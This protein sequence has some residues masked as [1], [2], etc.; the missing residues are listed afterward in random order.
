MV[1]AFSHFNLM[2]PILAIRL[3]EMNLSTMQIG[4]FFMI[5]PAFYI[6]CGLTIHLISKK[7]EKRVRL[8][9]AI[10]GISV[11]YLFAGPSQLLYFPDSLLLMCIG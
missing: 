11:G 4:Y 6:V 10:F 3:T 1:L 9:V 8:I 2:E 7:I 5:S